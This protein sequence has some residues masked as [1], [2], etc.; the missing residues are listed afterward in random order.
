MGCKKAI[1]PDEDSVE[2]NIPKLEIKYGVRFRYYKCPDC[3]FYHIATIGKPRK[4]R[5]T[6]KQRRGLRRAYQRDKLPIESW[7][8]EGGSYIERD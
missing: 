5:L 7:E 4:I 8:N 3:S 6:S 1:Y 2:R